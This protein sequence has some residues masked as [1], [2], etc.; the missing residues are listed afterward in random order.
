[1]S[2]NDT[3]DHMNLDMYT[4]FHPKTVEYTFFSSA[5][6]TFSGID[7]MLGHKVNLN[8]FKKIGVIWHAS[9]LFSTL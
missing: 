5:R 3:S 2:L 9:F 6:G 7:P 4:R 1:M 8:R